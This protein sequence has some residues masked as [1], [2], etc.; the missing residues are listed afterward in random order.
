[1]NG[2]STNPDAHVLAFA[3][4]QVK[5][6]LEI[7][8]KLGGE[9]FGMC[10]AP[11]SKCLMFWFSFF[12]LLAVCYPLPTRIVDCQVPFSFVACQVDWCWGF[13]PPESGYIS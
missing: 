11:A 10:V 6:G 1:M 12:L 7:T 4:A 3:A 13:F 5:K 2:A 8:K 9:N